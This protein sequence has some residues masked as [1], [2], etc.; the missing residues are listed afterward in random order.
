MYKSVKL[1]NESLALLGLYVC[2]GETI[3]DINILPGTA[4]K[5]NLPVLG[6]DG[7]GVV[8]Y[9]NTCIID[10]ARRTRVVKNN[11]VHSNYGSVKVYNESLALLGLYVYPGET[12]DDINLLPGIARAKNVP[13]LGHDGE[14]LLHLVK[15]GVNLYHSNLNPI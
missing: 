15:T 4:S 9:K 13:V 11:Q 8:I 7:D 14:E 1:Y 2:P 3:D 6:H 10:N 12:I 5:K